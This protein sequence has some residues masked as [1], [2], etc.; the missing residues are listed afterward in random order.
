MFEGNVQEPSEFIETLRR[1]HEAPTDQRGELAN[2]MSDA[3]IHKRV[4]L[5]EVRQAL[6]DSGDAALM[7]T[8]ERLLDLIE[9]YIEEGGVE[10]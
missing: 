9:P 1:Y 4:D 10:E 6:L 3:I 8:L 7:D 2:T 5:A